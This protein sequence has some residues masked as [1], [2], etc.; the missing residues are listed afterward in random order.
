M[1][2]DEGVNG[3]DHVVL[4]G[5]FET[6]FVDRQETVAGDSGR[7]SGVNCKRHVGHRQG[8]GV[9]LGNLRIGGPENASKN[10]SPI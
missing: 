8:F 9:S 3:G 6:R 1:I 5:A 2:H 10:T 4:R 7:V